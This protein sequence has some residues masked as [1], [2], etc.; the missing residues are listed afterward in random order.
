MLC[1]KFGWIWSSGSGEEV[2][3][4]K[5]LQTDDGQKVIRKAHLLSENILPLE[6]LQELNKS[7]WGLVNFHSSTSWF[8][9]YLATIKKTFR[10]HSQGCNIFQNKI[11]LD[12]CTQNYVTVTYYFIIIFCNILHH[13]D[14]LVNIYDDY[15]KKNR[16]PLLLHQ[17]YRKSFLRLFSLDLLIKLQMMY[18]SEIRFGKVS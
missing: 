15:F 3:N 8:I 11:K 7:W 17:N 12:F 10:T 14:A 4:V 16:I 1:A 2:E 6:I 9:T 18:C 5:R 13:I